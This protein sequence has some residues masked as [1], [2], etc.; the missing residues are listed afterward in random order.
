[1]AYICKN[2]SDSGIESREKTIRGLVK[3]LLM[4]SEYVD[5]DGGDSFETDS[6]GVVSLELGLNDLFNITIPDE[7]IFKVFF[8]FEQDGIYGNNYVKVDSIVD[9]LVKKSDV[10]V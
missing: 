5:F 9:Y 2:Y 4:E 6:L 7:D 1:M 8:G 3:K 10:R